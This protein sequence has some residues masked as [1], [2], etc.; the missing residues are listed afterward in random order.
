MTV[1]TTIQLAHKPDDHP[2][3][4]GSYGPFHLPVVV[5]VKDGAIV[6]VEFMSREGAY[7]LMLET[8]D[9][10]TIATLALSEPL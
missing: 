10:R 7:C 2:V 6:G 1:T 5:V 8:G 9:G 4:D 3:P